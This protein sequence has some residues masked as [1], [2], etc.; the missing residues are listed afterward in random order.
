MVLVLMGVSGTGKTTIGKALVAGLGWTFV[1]GDDFHP[2]ANIEKLRAGTP[3]DDQDRWPW[4][5]A[6]RKRVDQ[7][8]EQR[9][10]L[11]LACSA[12]KRDYREYLER[13]DPECVRYVYLHGSEDLIRSRLAERKGHFMNPTLLRSQFE[14]LEPP[15][16]A[17]QVDVNPAPEAIAAEIRRKLGL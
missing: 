15:E 9:E 11:V 13:N 7:A 3:L 2:V 14:T 8:C 17:L 1:E 16:G 4:L 5:Q 6:L 10:N 12:L